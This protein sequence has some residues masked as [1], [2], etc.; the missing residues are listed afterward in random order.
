MPRIAGGMGDPVRNRGRLH[1]DDVQGSVGGCL[2]EMN[3]ARRAAGTTTNDGYRG[4]VHCPGHSADRAL[5]QLLEQ[6]GPELDRRS[7]ASLG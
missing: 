1:D 7:P 3:C 5:H 4:G 2:G 6:S